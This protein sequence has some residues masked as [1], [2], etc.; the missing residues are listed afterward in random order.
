MF[1]ASTED[2]STR[3]DF[4]TRKNEGKKRYALR[5]RKNENKENEK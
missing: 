5:S 3:T 1:D 2:S 4:G